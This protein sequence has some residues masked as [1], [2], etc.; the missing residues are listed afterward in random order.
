V[1]FCLPRVDTPVEIWNPAPSPAPPSEGSE[2]ILLV[3]D[4]DEVRSLACETLEGHGYVVIPAG[5]AGEAL[6]LAT[7]SSRPIH[8]LSS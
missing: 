5:S 7:N 8:L 2:T 4:E 1:S 3:E 6:H